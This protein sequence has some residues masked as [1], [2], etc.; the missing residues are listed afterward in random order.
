MLL[1]LDASV[2]VCAG[3]GGQESALVLATI[4]LGGLE[5]VIAE[6]ALEEARAHLVA[7]ESSNSLK[8]RW[9]WSD[10]FLEW[11]RSS[12]TL[13][14]LPWINP[15]PQLLPENR[16][17]AYLWAAIEL[18]TPDCLLT[19]DKGLLAQGSYGG[20]SILDPH[21]LLVELDLD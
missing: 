11:F 6:N 7:Q 2:V 19:L 17:D 14:V 21:R 18:S 8:V 15:D 5:G 9:K 3:L 10:D 20:A 12:P 16:K 1:L 13:R 4:N